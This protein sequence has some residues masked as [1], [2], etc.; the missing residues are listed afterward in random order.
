MT[1]WAV[2]TVI[3]LTWVRVQPRVTLMRSIQFPLSTRGSE[4]AGGAVVDAVA[5]S[6]L[7]RAQIVNSIF[8][9]FGVGGGPKSLIVRSG[10]PLRKFCGKFLALPVK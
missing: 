9:H 1:S 3:E 6:L 8:V 2:L 4:F 10:M 5:R 7:L